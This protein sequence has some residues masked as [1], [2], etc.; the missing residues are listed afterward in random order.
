VVA[1]CALV[2]FA[3]AALAGQLGPDAPSAPVAPVASV[4]PVALP[5]SGAPATASAAA[6]LA[7]EVAV[8]AQYDAPIAD[9]RAIH[10]AFLDLAIGKP[11]WPLLGLSGYVG[12]T[13]THAWGSITQYGEHFEDVVFPTSVVG[14]GGLVL[15]RLQPLRL[16]PVALGGDAVGSLILYDHHFPPGGDVYN[17]S[18]RA[19]PSL[20]LRFT[21]RVAGVAGF[22]WMHV[23][24]GQGLGPQNPFYAGRGLDLGVVVGF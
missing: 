17:F 22:R 14:A 8:D 24:N 2:A 20:T 6:P 15:L 5:T 9:G 7:F 18:W 3:P 12:L 16:G 19:G 4:A 11:L 21:D 10:S 1:A 13:F 23:S